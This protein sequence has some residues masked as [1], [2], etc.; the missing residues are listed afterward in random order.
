MSV[1]TTPEQREQR[2]PEASTPG[3]SWS[4]RVVGSFKRVEWQQTLLIALMMAIGW[5]ALFLGSS[6]L[7]ILAG[8]VPVMA[9]LYLGR[10]VKGDWLMHGLVLGVSGFFFGL[11]VVLIYGGLGEAGFVEL[12]SL[13]ISP[14][15]EPTQ[16][17]MQE[18]LFFYATFSV[19]ALIPFP[20]FGT[21]MSG[22][23]EQR[24]RQ[25]QQEVAERGGRLERPGVVRTLEDLRGLSLPQL[26]SFVLN[27]YRKKGFE[28]TDYRFTD[29]DKHLDLDMV[30]EGEPYILRLTVVDKVRPGTLESLIQD[31]R[32]RSI[33]KGL[34]ITSTE[35]TPD[36]LKSGRDRKN[37]ILI[38]GQTL[39]DI[40]ES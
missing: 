35:F 12:P 31:M 28:F 11:I 34:V 23:A 7:Q 5:C 29:K 38:D 24:N 17:T 33:N 27:L 26:G 39:F 30:Y 36:A 16:V 14:E 4:E 15:G 22:R 6:I 37:I 3:P 25:L 10:R 8:I 2:T 19:F 13:Q 20:A 9:G 1:D 18:L 21:V 40:S 32:R